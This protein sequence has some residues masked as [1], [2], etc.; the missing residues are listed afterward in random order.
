ME[1]KEHPLNSLMTETMTKIKGMVDANTVVGNPIVTPEVTLIP[2]SRMSMG[3][4][5]GGS[6][7]SQ[8][9]Q[10]PDAPNAFGG[11]SGAGVS[12]VPMAFIVVRGENVRLLPIMPPNDALDRAVAMAPELIEKISNVLSGDRSE[13]KEN[14]EA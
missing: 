7:F 4:A 12:I 2:I 10:K 6:D 3:F 13:K 5:S 14:P 9:N 1:N 11:G 8:K